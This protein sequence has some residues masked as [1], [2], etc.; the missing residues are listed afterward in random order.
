MRQ[1]IEDK[2]RQAI[3]DKL[4]MAEK[5]MNNDVVL[6]CLTW[7]CR[8]RIAAQCLQQAR[9]EAHTVAIWGGVIRNSLTARAPASRER[10]R[11]Y[12]SSDFRSGQGEPVGCQMP[13]STCREF[14]VVR[15]R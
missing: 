13:N 6:E 14:P 10:S 7:K 1:A 4:T 9:Q 8:Q 3:E 5:S 11:R 15:R 2:L 12:A